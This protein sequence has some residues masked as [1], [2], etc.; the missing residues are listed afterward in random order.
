MPRLKESH[1]PLVFISEVFIQR[2]WNNYCMEQLPV[3]VKDLIPLC[4]CYFCDMIKRP[5]SFPTCR[6]ILNPTLLLRDL[7]T[8]ECEE[9]HYH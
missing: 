2:L 4:L 1:L 3:R 6:Q 7:R 8:R 5:C 9:T